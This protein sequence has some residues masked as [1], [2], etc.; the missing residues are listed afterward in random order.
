LL[1][2][3]S[4]L[5]IVVAYWILDLGVCILILLLPLP[6]PLPLLLITISIIILGHGGGNVEDSIGVPG[7][8]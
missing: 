2:D 1:I 3:F 7:V 5:F 4:C 6:L 8:P